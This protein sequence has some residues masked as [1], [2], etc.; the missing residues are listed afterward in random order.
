[1]TGSTSNLEV[2][3]RL[4]D[5]VR[6]DASGQPYA[7][8]ERRCGR[9]TILVVSPD[10]AAAA[11]AARLLAGRPGADDGAVVSL[12][13]APGEAPSDRS[14]ALVDDGK[15]LG[16]LYRENAAGGN[17]PIALVLSP[18][19]TVRAILPVDPSQPET[20][21]PVLTAF[22][23]I[24]TADGAA[25][26][27]SAGAPVLIIPEVLEPALCRSLIDRFEQGQ[28]VESGM[29]RW[30]DGRLQVVPDPSA[31]SRRDL[32]IDDPAL[33]ET[34]ARRL[35]RRVLPEIRKSFYF[36]VTRFEAFKIVRYDALSGGYFRPHRDNTTPD[37]AHRRFAMTLNLNTGDYSGG[38]LRFPEYGPE[39]YSPPAGAAIVFSCAH[40]HE[41]LDV[42]DG[43][44]YVL[45]TF[46]YGDAEARQRA[47]A[48]A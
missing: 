42:E 43:R 9:R 19:L 1:M 7:F 32:T 48:R 5:F 10:P 13:R 6:P 4:P 11:A 8:Y 17:R 16:L 36:P 15:V 24:E 21:D 33:T 47:A 30:I 37:A 44:R 45:L 34:I 46:F 40:L 2:G 18:R 39:R 12:G 23:A 35:Q 27:V 14:M 38:A 31:K 22:E 29:P 26:L 20:V 41:V 28:T 3:D 25:A